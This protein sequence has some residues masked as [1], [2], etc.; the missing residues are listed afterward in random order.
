MSEELDNALAWM[1]HYCE[2]PVRESTKN[3]S[4]E[5]DAFNKLVGIPMGSPY[6][7]S[8]LSY[9]FHKF[10]S[11]ADHLGHGFPSS[12][13]SQA[14]KRAFRE[15]GLYSEDPQD[16]LEW[17]GALGGWTNKDKVHGHIFMISHRLTNAQ[18]KL[19]R[20]GT[21]EANTSAAT[22]GRDGEGCFELTREIPVDRGHRLWF[23]RC[24]G[25]KGGAWWT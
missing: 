21:A 19:L 17:K 14:I 16:I 15:R 5:I 24:D 6:C 11:P 1:V 22:G 9:C 2:Q 13:S 12:G 23:L 10:A 18:G 20:I 25:I 4:A 8:C 7:A 3:R